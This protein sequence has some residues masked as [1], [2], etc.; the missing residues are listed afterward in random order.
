MKKKIIALCLVVCLLAIAVI[1]GTLAYFTDTTEAE[2]AV[3]HNRT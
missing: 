1:G 3:A 2:G